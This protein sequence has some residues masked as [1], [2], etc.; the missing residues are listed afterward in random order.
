MPHAKKTARISTG[1]YHPPHA[2]YEPMELREEEIVV[3]EDTDEDS[4]EDL[5]F[6]VDAAEDEEEEP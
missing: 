1:R 5:V 6:E 2:L 4:E 3:V